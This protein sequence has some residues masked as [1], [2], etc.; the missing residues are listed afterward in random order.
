MFTRQVWGIELGRSAVKAV[1]ATTSGRRVKVLDAAIV[2][3]EGDP[4]AEGVSH[5]RDPR[6]WEAMRRLQSECR[7]KRTPV[8]L[9]IPPQSILVRDLE[10]ACVGRKKMEEMVAFEAA[11]EIPFVLDEVAWDYCLFPHKSGSATRTGLLLAVKKNIITAYLRGI[12][13][14]DV[15]AVD[16]V[17]MAPLALLNFVR[18]ELAHLG[19]VLMAD[20]G[21]S[22]TNLIILDPRRFW[23]RSLGGGGDDMTHIL[24]TQ[25]Q[26]DRDA[27][28][29][30]KLNL[31][32][33][34][35]AARI[36][37]AVRPA[38]DD[39][40]REVHTNVS[41]L[42]TSEGLPTLD[43]ACAVG[44]GARLPGLKKLLTRSLRKEVRGIRKLHRVAL[45]P[46]ADADFIQDNM[47]RL[48]VALGAAITGLKRDPDDVSF[49]PKSHEQAARLSR[50]RNRILCAGL[51]VWLV[52]LT[53]LGFGILRQK[54][55]SEA[56]TVF[57]SVARLQKANKDRLR[58]AQ[59]KQKALQEEMDYLLAVGP[60]KNQVVEVLDSVLTA[61]A[62]ISGGVRFRIESFDSQEVEV[63]RPPRHPGLLRVEIK[64]FYETTGD[65]DTAV[66]VLTANLLNPLRESLSPVLLAVKGKLAKGSNTVAALKGS[67]VL[68]QKGAPPFTP[69]DLLILKPG[70]WLTP[71]LPDGDAAV[72]EGWEWYRIK[73]A[74]GGKIVLT[75]PFEGQ[76][77]N[78]VDMRI[79]RIDMTKLNVTEQK[80]TLLIELPRRRPVKTADL[81]SVE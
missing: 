35:H 78:E 6:L 12:A 11:N 38:M 18:L 56:E 67:D 73:S 14:L 41:Y 36:I 54:K 49:L 32:S 50:S 42:E 46:S 45:S 5:A 26:L 24:S 9:T 31:A 29:V 74:E 30:A 81:I 28:E 19:C 34:P 2:P 75:R 80:M 37:G 59:S 17:T 4:P 44:G 53:L 52:L 23:M 63:E 1:L 40:V 25:F 15:A 69:S 72:P 43:V 60:G 21:A 16:V 48:A 13:A 7:I 58:G 79:V 76:S 22:G 64:L 39:L 47:D 61:F 3:L 55:L 20:V 62:K 51:G 65:D 70:D 27:A 71:V 8:C 77:T 10:V 57:G 33:S 66:D 68:K